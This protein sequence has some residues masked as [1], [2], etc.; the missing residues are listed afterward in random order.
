MP[1]HISEPGQEY[2]KVQISLHGGATWVASRIQPKV[3]LRDGS[4]E[5]VEAEWL[6]DPDAGATLGWIDWR[7]VT[8]ITWRWSGTGK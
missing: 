1:R 3:L 2:Y 6:D 5:G 4:L 8:A 7:A